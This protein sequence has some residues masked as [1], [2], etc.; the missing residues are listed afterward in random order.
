MAVLKLTEKL[1]LQSHTPLPSGL[2]WIA[3]QR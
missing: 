1:R 3:E 2:H